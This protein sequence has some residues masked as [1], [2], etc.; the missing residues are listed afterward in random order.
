MAI[1]LPT[2]VS[3]DALREF[4]SLLGSERVISSEEELHEWRD[5]FQPS[6]WDEYTASAV[7]M[8]ETVQEIQ[9]IVRIASRHGVPLWALGQGRNNGYGGPAPR[10]RGSVIVSLRNMNRVLEMN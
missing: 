7:V 4:E 10:V 8:P 9:E 3:I 2:S 5:P 6:N 1:S